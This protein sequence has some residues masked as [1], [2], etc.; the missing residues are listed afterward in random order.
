MKKEL[1]TSVISV[2][3]SNRVCPLKVPCHWWF[4][5]GVHE[6]Y[7][8]LYLLS[9]PSGANHHEGFSSL[10]IFPNPTTGD[11]LRVQLT[12]QYSLCCK[13]CYCYLFPVSFHRTMTC[14]VLNSTSLLW[15]GYTANNGYPWKATYILVYFSMYFQYIN[16]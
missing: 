15:E 8:R 10:L 14:L 2:G 12:V 4:I 13:C 9:P 1:L 6:T 7:I 16:C 3:G 11:K 5:R